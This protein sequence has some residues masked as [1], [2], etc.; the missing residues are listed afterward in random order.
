MRV[1]GRFSIFNKILGIIL[2]LGIQGKRLGFHFM[3]R[4]YQT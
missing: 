4:L 2:I 3:K 1:F